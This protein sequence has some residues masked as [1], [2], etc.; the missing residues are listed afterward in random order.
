MIEHCL[1][2]FV[3]G[4]SPKI[5]IKDGGD[6]AFYDLN[7]MYKSQ[8]QSK[9]VTS[10]F[11]VKDKDFVIHNLRV[12]PDYQPQH[13]LYFCAHKRAVHQENLSG[14]VPNLSETLLDED[15]VP[16]VYTGCISG[17]YLDENV[18]PSRRVQIPKEQG[19]REE[20]AWDTFLAHSSGAAGG[21]V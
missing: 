3:L 1:E 4:R 11:K 20:L 19:L 8:V 14:K 21:Y 16:F 18:N 17:D 5:T 13:R 12:D 7:E 15:R 2:H 6:S 10:S 9:L